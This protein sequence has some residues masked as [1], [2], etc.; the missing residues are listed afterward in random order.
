MLDADRW[1]QVVER[2]VRA[3][4]IHNTQPWSFRADGD[5]LE[6]RHDP[7]RG[8]PA[9]DPTGRQQVL[10]VGVA[11]QFAV[12]ALAAL[13]AAAEVD[14]LPDPADPELVAVVRVIG[15]HEP[16]DGDRR[17]AAAIGQRHTDRAR[18]LEQPLPAG[19]VDQLERTLGRDGVWLKLI[20]RSEEETAVTTLLGEAEESEQRDPAYLA[21]L[22]AWTRTDPSAL[23]GVPADAVPDGEQRI[24]NVPVRD[25][26]TARPAP[27]A[28][29]D[30][31]DPAPPVEHPSVLL[32]GTTADDRAAWVRA[33]MALGRLLLALT[34]A[35][36]VAS[37][38][39]Q[40]L[41]QSWA[42]ARL[43]RRLDLVG[44]PQMLLR[45]GA[46]TGAAPSTGR[47]PVAEVLTLA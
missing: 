12:V 22:R 27:V 1:T 35:G 47:R 17:A 4:S 45:L 6:V 5:R 41:D 19:L 25:F 29:P 43:T 10:S 13:G 18:F 16:T 8:L 46:P 7:S 15:R 24:S 20:S 28:V 33:G 21:E 37:P 31:D 38:L 44:H 30:D 40:A 23:D 42:R 14:V 39:T 36:L 2:A 34:E 32:L 26:G 9:I 3:P 11:V